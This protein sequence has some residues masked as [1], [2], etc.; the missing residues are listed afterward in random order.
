[1]FKKNC[2]FKDLAKSI[3]KSVS[4]SKLLCSSLLITKLNYKLPNHLFLETIGVAS[5]YT[6]QFNPLVQTV[7][8]CV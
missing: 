4:Y 5:A 6:T 1:L 2:L 8:R 3:V 7:E